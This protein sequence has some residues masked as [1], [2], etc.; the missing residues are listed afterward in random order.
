MEKLIYRKA[1]AISHFNVINI[2]IQVASFNK[3]NEPYAPWS[4][5]RFRPGDICC[6]CDSAFSLPMCFVANF[7]QSYL[8]IVSILLCILYCFR[9]IRYQDIYGL[10][11]NVS[12]FEVVIYL[13]WRSTATFYALCWS[14]YLVANICELTIIQDVTGP[15][16]QLSPKNLFTEYWTI[17]DYAFNVSWKI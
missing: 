16:F 17:S 3:I 9:V 13:S 11:Y 6:G 14:S 10:V 4:E 12:S 8:C 2:V 7:L 1:V 15:C 5:R